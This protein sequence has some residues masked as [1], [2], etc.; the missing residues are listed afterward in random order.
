MHVFI[1]DDDQK[2]DDD[3]IVMRTRIRMRVKMRMMRIKHNQYRYEYQSIAR[4]WWK[5][6]LCKSHSL[7]ISTWWFQPIWKIC[8]SN[9]I[10]S[11]GVGVKIKH[12]YIS[13]HYLDINGCMFHTM[14][15]ALW[16]WTQPD[17]RDGLR[18]S[19][20]QM[21]PWL[22]TTWDLEQKNTKKLRMTMKNDEKWTLP[23]E[24]VSLIIINGDFPA[25]HLKIFRVS[26]S[27]HPIRGPATPWH[28]DGGES[29]QEHLSKELLE[30]M[31]I[32]PGFPGI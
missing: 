13:C 26:P 29:L 8:S 19:V 2:G 16:S 30:N 18:C 4:S 14:I 28:T 6:H 3:M 5:L 15:E 32:S 27:L 17:S 12:I 23:F 20:N 24:D 9:W 22:D 31:A 7:H 10:V 11:P 1:D 25:R 21:G